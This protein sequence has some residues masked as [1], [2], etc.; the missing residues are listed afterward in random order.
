MDKAADGRPDLQPHGEEFSVFRRCLQQEFLSRKHPALVDTDAAFNPGQAPP[1]PEFCPGGDAE[2]QEGQHREIPLAVEQ[3]HEE[4][5]TDNDQHD[6]DEEKAWQAAISGIHRRTLT[7]RE[8]AQGSDGRSLR[9]ETPGSHPAA[10]LLPSGS[11]GAPG[12]AP[13]MTLCHRAA[14]SPGRAAPPGPDRPA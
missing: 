14:H 9:E 13:P 10:A 1:C 6:G 7:R 5:Q 2:K 8:R 11:G 12:R 3:G 4:K